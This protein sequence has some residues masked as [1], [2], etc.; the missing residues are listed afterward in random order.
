[1]EIERTARMLDMDVNPKPAHFP[2]NM[3][4]SS[5]AVIAA[6]RAGGGD[7][8]ALVAGLTRACWAEERDI[9]GHL[10][11]VAPEHVQ[12]LLD[13]SQKM[14]SLDAPLRIDADLTLSD[15]IPD[16]AAINPESAAIRAA[17]DRA[18]RESLGELNDREQMILRERAPFRKTS[19]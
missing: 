1:M 18:V 12:F 13:V 3:A 8:A 7:M 5:Y 9:A 10:P 11:G 2:T 17:T 19:G 15:V 16:P 14:I 6:G 4:P